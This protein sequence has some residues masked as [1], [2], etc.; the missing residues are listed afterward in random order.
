MKFPLSLSGNSI[1]FTSFVTE[2]FL[3]NRVD[4][5]FY[6]SY[7]FGFEFPTTG[8]SSLF[9]EL[10]DD[11]FPFKVE[12]TSEELSVISFVTCQRAASYN[13]RNLDQNLTVL[14]SVL[15]VYTVW[16]KHMESVHDQITQS[17]LFS[18]HFP[19][20]ATPADFNI[21]LPHVPH[22]LNMSPRTAQ[23]LLAMQCPMEM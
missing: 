13:A 11:G 14:P 7:L 9:V 8:L 4:V 2:S 20:Y 12:V 6:G 19:H 18:L 5:H 3:K 1:I 22:S 17:H 16:R 15:F 23:L 21:L 10:T